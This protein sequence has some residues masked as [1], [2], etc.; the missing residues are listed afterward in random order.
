MRFRPLHTGAVGALALGLATG[1]QSD[2]TKQPTQLLDPTLMIGSQEQAFFLPGSAFYVDEG[3]I[4]EHSYLSV[5]R[6][7]ATVPGVY[8]RE[9]DG[10]GNFPNISIRGADGTRSEKLTVMEDGIPTAPAPYAAPSAYYSPNA[11]RMAGLELLKGSSQVK[12]GPHTTGGAINYLSTPVPEERTHYLKGIYGEDGT[13]L[14]HGYYGNTLT[15]DFGR[16]GYLFELYRKQSDGYRMIDSG[17]GFGGSDETG[18][19]LTEPML[20]LFWEPNSAAPQRFEFKYGYTDLDADE[21]Y[22]GLTEEDVRRSPSR[23]Y[24]GTYLDNIQTEHHRTYLKYRLEPRDNVKLSATA[25]YNEF[26]RNWYK[27]S[28]AGGES[29]HKVL[30]RPGDYAEAF[31][32]L[33]LRAPG[34]LGISANIRDYEAYGLQLQS[35]VDF[36]TGDVRHETRTGV[37]VHN[38]EVSRLQRADKIIVTSAGPSVD[39]GAPGSAGNRVENADAIAA[40]LEHEIKSGPLTVTP[41]IR[42]EY[43]D[44]SYVDYKSDNTFTRTGGGSASTDQVVPGIGAHLQLTDRDTVFASVYKG[45]SAPGPRSFVKDDVD[46]EESVGYELGYRSQLDK[47]Y[48]ETVAFF[49]DYDN[50]IGTA[51]GLGQDGVSSGNAG[52]AEVYGL[53]FLASYDPYR[54][55]KVEMPLFV[56]ATWTEATLKNPLE[57]GGEGDILA[58]GEANADLPYVP[59]WKLAAGAGLKSEQWGLDLVATYLSDTYGTANNIDAPVSTARE[60]EIEGGVIVDVSG[61]VQLAKGVRLLL[62][63]NNLFDE[64]LISSRIPEGPRTSAPRMAYVGFELF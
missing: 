60:G 48:F 53:E 3:Q 50:L 55:E 47:A 37:R 49:S 52:E 2:E 14:L 28:S 32:I 42:Y 34:E 62:G 30:G 41:G 25:Y 57:S 13:A 40:W 39:R 36:E 20:K 18:F 17:L 38:D 9:E 31:D 10:F 15:G 6:I 63:V 51:A 27:I 19:N 61:Y 22:T 4:R 26:S 64:Q 46:W 54:G 58:G 24:A 43:I 1:V 35:A 11:G 29:I 33:R 59:E 7:L 45:I 12:Y 56:S 5:N 44:Y 21:T 16:F 23:R 8:L